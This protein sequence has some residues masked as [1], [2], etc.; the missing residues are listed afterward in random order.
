MVSLCNEDV[1]TRILSF[2]ELREIRFV[3]NRWPR[4]FGGAAIRALQESGLWRAEL[5][6]RLP[7][8]PAF[9]G[10]VP[11]RGWKPL[12]EAFL[13][14]SRPG[15][16]ARHVPPSAVVSLES[17]EAEMA[18]SRDA[19]WQQGGV[20]LVVSAV[21]KRCRNA[22]STPL[23]ALGWSLQL[24]FQRGVGGRRTPSYLYRAERLALTAADALL[25][26][27]ASLMG[28]SAR[29]FVAHPPS[30]ALALLDERFA[31]FTTALQEEEEEEDENRLPRLAR[32]VTGLRLGFSGDGGRDWLGLEMSPKRRADGSTDHRPTIGDFGF[33]LVW[34]YEPSPSHLLD[35]ACRA[36]PLGRRA[37][38]ASRLQSFERTARLASA[39]AL[40]AVIETIAHHQPKPSSYPDAVGCT[41][42]RTLL[43]NLHQLAGLSDAFRPEDLA[44]NPRVKDL[45]AVLAARA[46]GRTYGPR[47]APGTIDFHFRRK[48]RRDGGARSPAIDTAAEECTASNCGDGNSTTSS[49]DDAKGNER[50]ENSSSRHRSVV[51]VS[52]SI[53]STT[54]SSFGTLSPTFETVRSRLNCASRNLSNS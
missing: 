14:E 38:E 46:H 42:P 1:V 49:S 19:W 35:L 40:H 6:Q 45:H 50:G 8:L 16:S 22:K 48:R 21:D 26:I 51:D 10:D 53:S 31:S 34:L 5:E 32:L 15:A 3:S 24:C 41:N 44:N 18:F 30:G 29:L 33:K 28:V 52:G 17:E 9:L 11:S 13:S 43:T 7:G 4:R 23:V 39:R 27:D 36:T 2:L 20:L 54:S 47:A 37:L 25:S 12:L